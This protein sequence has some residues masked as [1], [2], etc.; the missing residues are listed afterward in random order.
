MADF[1][2]CSTMTGHKIIQI[3]S[4]AAKI[5]VCVLLRVLRSPTPLSAAS[6]KSKEKKKN[7]KRDSYF[8]IAVNTARAKEALLHSEQDLY[9]DSYRISAEKNP[10]RFPLLAT[11]TS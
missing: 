3:V 11:Y 9:R 2:S 5:P 7:K 4:F 10:L 6:E 1:S 8:Y